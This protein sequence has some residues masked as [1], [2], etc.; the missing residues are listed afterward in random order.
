MNAQEQ[1]LVDL[2]AFL[3]EHEFPYMIIGGMANA[4]WGNP[5][6]TLDVDVTLW[7]AE[8]AH[9]RLVALLQS[10]YSSRVSDPLL[11]VQRT[12]V[13]PLVS[14][15]GVAIDVMFG[16]LPFEQEAITRA[17]PRLIRGV[18]VR[19]CTAEDLILMKI[20]SD[21]PKDIDDARQ[22]VTRQRSALDM[23][24]LTPRVAELADL[25]GRPE[26]LSRLSAWLDD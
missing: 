8:A 14:V 9:P 13:L 15:E 10:R 4:V 5:R 16:L 23:E 1:A 6:S 11:F 3:T 12:R 22:V 25:L 20:I 24:Y 7:A 17:I 18:P 21:R 19:F 26:L 2:A